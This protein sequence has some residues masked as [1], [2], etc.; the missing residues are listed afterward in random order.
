M[1]NRNILIVEDHPF[2]RNVLLRIAAQNGVTANVV[3]TAKEALSSLRDSNDYELVIMDWQLA[4]PN[5]D[6]L[7]CTKRIRELDKKTGSRTIIVGLSGNAAPEDRQVCLDAGMDDYYTKPL[8][9]A[10]FQRIMT[11]WLGASSNAEQTC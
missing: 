11:K 6:G 8:S 2:Q 3:R 1:V 9:N 7:E 10:D 5:E 4:D